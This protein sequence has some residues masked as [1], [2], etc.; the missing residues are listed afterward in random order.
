LIHEFDLSGSRSRDVIDHVTVRFPIGYFL[1][2][3]LWNQ[4]SISNGFGDI[5]Q[6]MWR[7]GSRDLKRPLNRAERQS[8]RMSKITNDNLTRSDTG[9]V[10]AVP[11]WQQW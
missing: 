4:G 6:R 7:N 9:Y 2:M 11:V 10:K 8:A 1:L 3:V 5:Y